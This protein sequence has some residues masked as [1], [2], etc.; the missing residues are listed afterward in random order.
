MT[1]KSSVALPHGAM[2]CFQ[3]AIVVF[4]DHTNLLL[5][6]SID[7]IISCHTQSFL[8]GLCINKAN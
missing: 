6:L 5:G 1:V 7:L 4:T 3:C 8:V 2:T